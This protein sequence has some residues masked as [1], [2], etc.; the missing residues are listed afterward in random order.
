MTV[1]WQLPPLGA[2]CGPGFTIRLDSDFIGPIPAGS[3]WS[4]TLTPA[5]DETAIFVSNQYLS[6]STHLGET[7]GLESG[8]PTGFGGLHGNVQ[9]GAQGLLTAVLESPQGILDQGTRQVSLE[10]NA[11][12]YVILSKVAATVPGGGFSDTDRADLQSA[13]ANTEVKVA[14]AGA[15]GDLVLGL[16]SIFQNWPR[17]FTNRHLT[18]RVTSSGSLI[19]G[20]EPFRFDAVGIEWSFAVV[21][22]GIG[23]LVG[24]P[25]EKQLRIAQW[26]LIGRDTAGAQFQQVVVDTRTTG[27]S[28]VWGGLQPIRL[29]WFVTPGCE[30]DLT[31]LVPLLG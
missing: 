12:Q 30:V 13:K 25:P 6:Q 27:E 26:R 21:P 18:I 29:E 15:I 22:P 11:G 10:T 9:Q 24:N 31:F 2:P 8:V 16:G 23:E 1:I 3:L 20:T 4:L 7:L 19:A 5:A 28:Y 17:R 14:S